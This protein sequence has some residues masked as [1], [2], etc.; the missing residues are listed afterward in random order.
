[1]MPDSGGVLTETRFETRHA[2]ADKAVASARSVPAGQPDRTAP[3]EGGQRYTDWQRIGRGGSANVFRVWDTQ[4]RIHLAIKVLRRDVPQTERNRELMRREVL[5]SR[6][7]RHQAICPVH[8]VHDGPE[9]FGVIMDLLQG[10]DLSTWLK[11]NADSLQ[12]TFNQRLGLVEKLAD[13]LA[14]AH[15]RI[16]HRDMKPSN[17]FLTDGDIERPLILDFGLSLLDADRGQTTQGG[18][19]RYMA[20]EQIEGR[21]DV[22]SD[23]FAL[24]VMAYEMLTGGVHPLGPQ[25]PRRP[26]LSDWQETSPQPP[27]THY[28]AI[29][30]ALDRLILQLLRV[31]PDHRPA[32]AK[33]V[34]DSLR[35]IARARADAGA[36]SGSADAPQD[37][38]L[39]A[40]TVAAGKHIVGSPPSAPFRTEKPM[41]R[42][43]LG[44]F[45]ITETPVTNAE[46]LT[47]VRATG[48]RPQPLLDHPVFGRP[49][50]P[51]VMLDW[52]EARAFAQ[53]VSGDLPTEAQWE[54][55]ARAGRQVCEYPWGDERPTTD[56]ANLDMMTGATSAVRA[57]PAG[58]NPL[59]LWD[60]SGNVWE[61]CRDSFSEQPY[62]QL[63]DGA[64][65]P[66]TVIDG[67]PMRVVRGGSYESVI[68]ACR[69]AF[70][71][72]AEQT[73]ARADIGFRVV[74]HGV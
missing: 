17:I 44:A 54:A 51:V 25:A 50:H 69:I 46:Y 36:S 7:I 60:L 24:G 9:G 73:Q 14:V 74:F 65:E 19:P 23:L 49:D 62:R 41:R 72:Q 11:Q 32:T 57:F 1:M 6:A 66:V 70:R 28:P 48:A 29:P 33:Q 38:G 39:R 10:I 64:V 63:R 5:V 12:E 2:A 71:H 20:P 13:A 8:D 21:P 58:R 4:L 55:A 31:N 27:S 37:D 45:R 18:T 47:Y 35:T 42:I 56:H 3:T 30:T 61:W 40:V 15:T 68:S 67:C 52:A 34:A 16:V 53:W 26:D 59:G 22:R 43:S